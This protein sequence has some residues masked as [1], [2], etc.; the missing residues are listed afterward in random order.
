[1]VHFLLYKILLKFLQ[2]LTAGGF[3]KIIYFI[4][5]ANWRSLGN[6][7]VMLAPIFCTFVYLAKIRPEEF[8]E[9]IKEFF[10]IDEEKD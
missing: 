2:L 8:D 5:I 4:I 9:M 3:A 6:M 1:M 7:S 10:E